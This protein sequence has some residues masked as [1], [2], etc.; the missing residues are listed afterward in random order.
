M[1]SEESLGCICA[2]QLKGRWLQP[3]AVILDASDFSTTSSGSSTCDLWVLPRILAFQAGMS[4]SPPPRQ[5]S[6]A[7]RGGGQ[8][9]AHS[10]EPQAAWK[11]YIAAGCSSPPFPCYWIWARE[12]GR[13]DWRDARALAVCPDQWWVHRAHSTCGAPS[14]NVLTCGWAVR[15]PSACSAQPKGCMAAPPY[16]WVHPR[17][18]SLNKIIV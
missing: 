6:T 9:N 2:I 16:R 8:M 5:L 12:K 18:S 15:A 3:L 1:H 4:P 7:G 17:P 14:K 11:L 10:T 13:E